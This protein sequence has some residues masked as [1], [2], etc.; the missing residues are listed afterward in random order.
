MISVDARDSNPSSIS[1]PSPIVGVQGRKQFLTAK[2]EM[3]D[4]YDAARNKARA[5]EA[6]TF[7]G[8]VAEAVFRRWLAEFLPKRYAVTSGFIVSQGRSELMKFPHFDVIIYDQLESPVLWIEGSPDSSQ[9][10]MSRAIP[11][12]H[13]CAV[14]EIKSAFHAAAVESAL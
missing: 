1:Q 4:E 3:L 7:H 10:G 2:K 13:V 14:L 12:E 8:K 11:V 6:E 5:H 9:Q